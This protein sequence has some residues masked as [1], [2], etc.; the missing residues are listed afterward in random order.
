MNITMTLTIEA[1]DSMLSTKCRSGRQSST[2]CC[3]G[4]YQI[5]PLNLKL[6]HNIPTSV[7]LNIGVKKNCLSC[8]L[9]SAFEADNMYDQ[10]KK[11][12]RTRTLGYGL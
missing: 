9:N 7:L 5:T 4:L 2:R 6:L 8:I 3:W 12:L 1:T 10:K 11:N